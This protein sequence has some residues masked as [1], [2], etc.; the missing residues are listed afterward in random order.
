MRPIDVA[1]KKTW[2][3]TST[4]GEAKLMK[5]LGNV[6]VTLRKSM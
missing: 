5:V 4:I 6:G 3:G 1:K 2:Y